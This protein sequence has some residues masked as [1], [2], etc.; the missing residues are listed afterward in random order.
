MP[1]I[2][3]IRQL[4]YKIRCKRTKLVT[5]LINNKTSKIERATPNYGVKTTDRL[6]EHCSMSIK[7]ARILEQC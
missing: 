5:I 4:K 7:V 2:T 3:Y 6:T 1:Y